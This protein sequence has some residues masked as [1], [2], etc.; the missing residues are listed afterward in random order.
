M[1]YYERVLQQMGGAGSV[2]PFYRFYLAPGLSHALQTN[3]TTK[4]AAN[5][6]APGKTQMLDV[7]T[8]WV[9]NGVEPQGISFTSPDGQKSLP[10]CEYPAIPVYLGG[11]IFQSGSY[12]CG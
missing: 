7:L 3:G 2:K 10:L 6:P 1:N 11:D 5:P 9:E 8:A 4:T 12:K